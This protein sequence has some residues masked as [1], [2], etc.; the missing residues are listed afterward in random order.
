MS[1]SLAKELSQRFEFGSPPI[2]YDVILSRWCAFIAG[3]AAIVI[4]TSAIPPAIA[5]E[6]PISPPVDAAASAVLQRLVDNPTAPKEYSADVK[7]HVRLRVF[8]WISLTFRGNEVY[9]HPG[10]YH[11]VF[12]G[13]PKAVEKFSDMAWSLGDPSAWPEKY[14][15][16]LVASPPSSSSAPSDKAVLRLVPKVRGLVKSLDVTIDPQ[17]GR[18]DHVA[19]SRYDGGT[20]VVTQHYQTIAAHDVVAE[21]DASIRIPHMSADLVATY[22]NFNVTQSV[23]DAH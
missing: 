19:W 11:F 15:I 16:A 22:S 6:T 7:L 13:V 9:K 21:Q 14:E 3:L 4:A 1:H 5:E 12:R 20:I 23:A 17:A 18:I 8:P 10:F 2:S